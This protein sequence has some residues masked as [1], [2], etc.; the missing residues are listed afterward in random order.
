MMKAMHTTALAVA[1]GVLMI[2]LGGCQKKDESAGQGTAEKAGQQIDQA[3]SK[4]GQE[5]N[6]AGEKVGEVMQKAGEKGG[7]A[8]KSAG[9]QLQNKSREAQQQ[10]DAQQPQ[11]KQ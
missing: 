9:E 2:G 5:L 1:A 3:A 11:Q 6:K 7:E 4:A 8:V 10:S